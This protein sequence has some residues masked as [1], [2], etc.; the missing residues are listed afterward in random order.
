M[1][2]K[3]SILQYNQIICSTTQQAIEKL[4]KGRVVKIASLTNDITLSVLLQAVFGLKSGERCYLKLKKILNQISA[5]FSNPL[6]GK[7]SHTD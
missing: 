3:E 5:L 7:K 6:F 2:H 4:E 1:F